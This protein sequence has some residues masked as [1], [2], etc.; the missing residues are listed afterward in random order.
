[1]VYCIKCGKKLNKDAKF[2]QKC[3]NKVSDEKVIESLKSSKK[4]PTFLNI[5]LALMLISYIFGVIVNLNLGLLIHAVL[6]GVGLFFVY[7]L[8]NWYKSGFYGIIVLSL[9]GA[10]ISGSMMGSQYFLFVL[11]SAGIGILILYWAM[12]PVWNEFK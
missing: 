2:C 4:R 11:I 5:W 1:M 12:K 3:G 9:I 8:Y 7:Q 10:V 6:G